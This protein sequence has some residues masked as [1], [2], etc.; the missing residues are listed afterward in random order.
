TPAATPESTNEFRLS[1]FTTLMEG[2]G[3]KTVTPFVK[4]TENGNVVYKGV[5]QNEDGVS[6]DM[7]LYPTSTYSDALSLQQQKIDDFTAKGYVEDTK[8]SEA[9]M[10]IGVLGHAGAMVQVFDTSVLETPAVLVTTAVM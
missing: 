10:W 3:Y 4:T 2:K 1:L 7:V 6:F 8:N 5:M 9:D